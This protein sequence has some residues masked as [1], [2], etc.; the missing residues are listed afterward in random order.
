MDA[1]AFLVLGG[2]FTSAMSGNTIVLGAALGQGQLTTAERSLVTFAAYICGAAGATL[3]LRARGGGIRRT[4]GLELL[5]LAAFVLWW[6]CGSVKNPFDAYGLIILSALAMGFQG[7]I[8]RALHVAGIPTTVVTSTLTAIV[9]SLAER[10]LAHQR[11]LASTTTRQQIAAFLAYLVGAVIGGVMVWAGWRV[12]LPLVPFAAV[13][14][15]W[16]E[17]Q[18]GFVRFEPD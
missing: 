15:L 16:L 6:T 7:G 5:V 8:G 10:A 13:L 18:L 1:I 9:E 12:A 2:V 17:L 14:A 3:P 4:L 11:P